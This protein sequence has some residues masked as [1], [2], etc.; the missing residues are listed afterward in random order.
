M[1]AKLA[2]A[3][4]LSY[5]PT[6][7]PAAITLVEQ[8]QP[9]AAIIVPTDGVPSDR[10]IARAR[11]GRGPSVA[12]ATAELVEFI[13]KA[14]G[15]TLPV[16]AEGREAEVRSFS[17]RIYV[18]GCAEN[19][20]IVAERPL[21]AEEY[22]LR[23][24]TDSLH[25][26]GGDLAPTGR[27]TAGTL[28]A[29]YTFLEDYVGVRWLFPGTLGEVV[30][31]QTRLAIP[32]IDRREQPR[33]AKRRI[34]DVALTR[35]S[36]FA[37]ILQQW[38]VPLSDW[39]RAFA[40]EINH[41]WFRRQRLGARLDIDAGHSFGG[42]YE[43]YFATHPDFF[44]V[45]PDGTRQQVP[46]R[47]RLCV[48]DPEIAEFVA[49]LRIDALKADPSRQSISISPNDGGANK[50]CLCERCRSWDP[51]TAPKLLANPALIDPATG[52]PL[53]EYPSLSDRYF[54]FFNAVARRVRAELPDRNVATC[55]YSVY[56]TPPVALGACE[57]NLI[58][59][60][61]GLNLEEIG[62]W[63]RLAPKLALRPNDL[64]P[65][66]ELGLP[67]NLAPRLARAVKFA[68]EHHAIG[69]DFDNCHGNWGGHGLDYYV[70]AHAL[71]NP[72]LD[73]AAIT[74]D[75]CRAAYGPAAEAMMRYFGE[76]EKVTDGAGGDASIGLRGG[77]P[78]GLLRYYSPAVMA[79][80]EST[81]A[82]AKRSLA[83]AD[84][85]CR[86]RL[87]MVEDSL[88]YARR[89]VALLEISSGP[90]ARKSRPYQERLA[91]VT[92]FLREKVLTQS[93]ASLHSLRY[94][95]LALARSDRTDE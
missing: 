86:A 64:G 58:V 87:A 66:V 70:L 8:L 82:E 90:A 51:P 47:E 38:G 94:L 24:T 25:I 81:V 76:L 67:R 71:W 59:C 12:L 52:K 19:Q 79:R 55:A 18:G 53:P 30:P 93:V 77:D 39:K 50:F 11:D 27:D 37:P 83:T 92:D 9:R 46:V 13:R 22:I 48:S 10:T 85:D 72:D 3:S 5:V 17:V 23:T 54:R 63:S 32:S 40:A 45:Q 28:N 1:A 36:I 78:A 57:P 84:G 6:R 62:A 56:R 7:A 31:R 80:L 26:L 34:R 75:Y 42:F 69:F 2:A 43:K 60:Y 65:M 4:I 16:L 74:A 14:T 20:R 73:V 15:A 88:E 21:Q 29:V 33:V 91:R 49:R 68:A 89:V 95:R 41:P 61:A 44:A 35:E